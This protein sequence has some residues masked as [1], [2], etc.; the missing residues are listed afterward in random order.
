[1]A[2][3]IHSILI[4]DDEQS[5]QI[6]SLILNGYG[7]PTAQAGNGKKALEQLHHMLPPSL[8][9]LDLQMPVMDGWTFLRQ[10]AQESELRRIPVVLVTGELLEN[11]VSVPVLH[12]PLQLQSLEPF[13]R[14]HCGLHG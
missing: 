4:D 1:V 9:L 8:I 13:L 6:L 5:R 2:A 12:K 3:A 11:P 7:L 14:R 10:R